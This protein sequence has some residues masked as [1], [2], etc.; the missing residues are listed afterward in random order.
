MTNGRGD[1]QKATAKVK[2]FGDEL[3]V[4]LKERNFDGSDGMVVVVFLR[5]WIRGANHAA[6]SEAHLRLNL[7]R[8]LKNTT[9]DH[10]IV[11]RDC[12]ARARKSSEG[13]RKVGAKSLFVRD[14]RQPSKSSNG[15]S[16]V[17]LLGQ[18][19]RGACERAVLG[20]YVENSAR[21][22]HQRQ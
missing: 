20:R 19:Q 7:P 15:S 12:S 21:H 14:E 5:S 11:I 3:Q 1:P 8:M 16:K 4:T 10:F 22:D 13:L 9:H 6:M 2:S 18:P 17:G